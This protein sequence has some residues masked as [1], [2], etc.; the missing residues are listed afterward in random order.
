MY[1]AAEITRLAL[2]TAC[3]AVLFCRNGF[4]LLVFLGNPPRE[5]TSRLGAGFLAGI[6]VFG[7]GVLALALAGILYPPLIIILLFGLA[8]P[9]GLSFRSIRAGIPVPGLQT[10]PLIVLALVIVSIVALRPMALM[11][12]FIYHLASGWQFL[13]AH[14]V[15][16]SD[17]SIGF[18]YPLPVEMAFIPALLTG[19]DRL[20]T[21]LSITSMAAVGLVA[22]RNMRPGMVWL[23]LLIAFSSGPLLTFINGKNDV[24]A[25][26][27]FVAGALLLQSGNP[28]AGAFLLGA[29]ASAKPVFI[30]L[31]ALWW[32][33]VRPRSSRL[34]GLET[35]VLLVPF[36]PWWGKSYLATG[37]PFYPFG[38]GII[39][40]F[41]RGAANI[42]RE[43]DIL[44][45]PGSGFVGDMFGT[46]PLVILAIP[47]MLFL[48]PS[49]RRRLLALIAA[50]AATFWLG[51]N[52]RYWMPAIFLASFF[53]AEA[54]FISGKQYLAVLAG[55][56]SVTAIFL[57]PTVRGF[58]SSDALPGRKVEAH[59]IYGEACEMAGRT[60]ARRF[61][62][63]G[64]YRTYLLPGRAVYDGMLGET[65][66]IWKACRESWTPQEVA[67]KIRQSG[68]GHL[69]YNYIAAYHGVASTGKWFPWDDRMGRIWMDYCRSGLELVA[70][71]DSCDYS[72]GGYYLYKISRKP[73]RTG[74]PAVF[75][76]P[77]AEGLSFR[78][79]TLHLGG[80]VPESLA[81]YFRLVRAYPGVLVFSC[82]MAAEQ[83]R[84]DSG[85]EA[86]KTLHP[87][88]LAGMRHPV[89]PLYGMAL[90]RIGDYAGARKYLREFLPRYLTDDTMIRLGLAG[91]CLELGRKAVKQGRQ[92]AA[93][94]FLEEAEAALKFRLAD[95]SREAEAMAQEIRDGI[96]LLRA[97]RGKQ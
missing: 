78:A 88:L 77:G 57:H 4:S 12:V 43:L 70:E 96:A 14:R 1:Q 23:G 89:M 80:A 17:V 86:I 6:L 75:Y 13:Q 74:A 15:L 72:S 5:N 63:V 47:G 59:R 30:P 76:L 41:G 29:C 21:C 93:E 66:Y 3:A 79:E 91:S 81:E 42:G 45:P 7:T 61:L 31:V 32:L 35:T 87:A 94:G 10:V 84:L 34:L 51:H 48:L 68:A 69:L 33:L 83:Y 82:G 65:P 64:E 39:D 37:N 97:K 53:T 27:F 92:A 56:W 40:T 25:S 60:K 18:L 16:V 9:G 38:A 46:N 90:N 22:I 26:S 36:I 95:R 71:S 49:H 67:K 2:L 52:T 58:S 8:L 85:R 55:A 28:R 62:V 11:D 20:T 44:S 19:D 73:R 24:I 50:S 54:V